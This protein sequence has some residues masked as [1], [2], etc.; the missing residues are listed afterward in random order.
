MTNY[1]IYA[2]DN[3]RVVL[4]D[5]EIIS[6]AIEQGK[7][8]LIVCNSWSGGYA[9]AIGAEEF[10]DPEFG[11]CYDMYG[12]DVREIEFN[13]ED[14]QKFYKVIFTPGEIIYMKT[15]DQANSYCGG[16]FTDWHSSVEDIHKRANIYP[17]LG[18][19]MLTEDEIFS[20]RK[21]VDECA[22]VRHLYKDVKAKVEALINHGILSKDAIKYI[23][24]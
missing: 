20:K 8:V 16:Q 11:R 17:S 6:N 12:Y 10:N 4:V 13:A 14:L 7:E 3:G 19:K 1:E 2:F 23:K 21:T 15:G 9:Y 22:T 24:K 5:S 18:D